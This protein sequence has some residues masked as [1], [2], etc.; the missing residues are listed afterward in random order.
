MGILC[1]FLTELLLSYFCLSLCSAVSLSCIKCLYTSNLGNNPTTAVTISGYWRWSA[2][3]GSCLSWHLLDFLA[4]K[5]PRTADTLFCAILP[6]TIGCNN[7]CPP[8]PFFPDK[9]M[10]DSF[11][12]LHLDKWLYQFSPAAL[13][14]KKNDCVRMRDSFSDAL[15]ETVEFG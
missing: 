6:S 13:A 5:S 4:F 2:D 3:S 7:I 15:F 10:Q 1:E 11:F 12:F 9:N 14:K 8:F